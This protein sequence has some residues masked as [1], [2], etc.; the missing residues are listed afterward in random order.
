MK[1][2]P[3]LLVLAAA[4][5]LA[6]LVLR[7]DEPPTA[8]SEAANATE[9]R[10]DEPARLGLVSPESSTEARRAT[11]SD[12]ALASLEV[13]THLDCAT[14]TRPSLSLATEGGQVLRKVVATESVVFDRLAPGTYAVECSGNGW[15]AATAR[16]SVVA[17]ETTQV[18]LDPLA[19]NGVRGNVVAVDGS[20]PVRKF[21][22]ILEARQVQA[23]GQDERTQLPPI[24]VDGSSGSFCVA[25]LDVASQQLRV[26]V[27]AGERGDATS[28][29][30][31]FDGTR[32][33][34]GVVLEVRELRSSTATLSG[35]IVRA[36]D[37]TPVADARVRVLDANVS[38]SDGWWLN[39]ELAFSEAEFSEQY[40]RFPAR[41]EARSGT[42][43][44]FRIEHTPPRAVRLFVMT[45]GL[46]PEL[47]D[48]LTLAAGDDRELP[49]IALERGAR[50]LGRIVTATAADARVERQAWLSGA[51]PRTLTRISERG[52][53]TFEG[54]TDGTWSLEIRSVD[55]QGLVPIV[56]LRTVE[57][58]DQQD[59]ALDIELGGAGNGSVVR[60]HVQLPSDAA[61][62]QWRAFVTDGEALA[63]P[64]TSAM[65]S[66]DGTFELL[67]VTP[68]AK[69]IVVI[70]LSEGMQPHA[71]GIAAVDVE[72]GRPTH[73][74]L[75]AAS[76]RVNLRVERAGASP[77]METVRIEAAETQPAAFARLVPQL[78]VAVS[79]D[80][81][82]E[83]TLYGLPPGEYSA[84]TVGLEPARFVVAANGPAALELVLR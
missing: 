3:W 39:G 73:V 42:D 10:A 44:S 1:L 14:F 72:P 78:F 75:D 66:A 82:G 46:R 68:G 74:D 27:D 36:S 62:R 15:N 6:F 11:A 9:R 53:F 23:N 33:L 63:P 48:V 50:L 64:E 58:V 45:P 80:A 37:R 69:L 52:E 4:L 61:I 20:G 17:S 41:F 47:T 25:A 60:G 70:G 19:R 32:W 65:V 16:V 71:V 28:E 54:L 81:R 34:D 18:R 12:V 76:V 67:D 13:T 77:S 7:S 24:E 51:L 31:P 22:L 5:G 21:Q 2:I 79:T 57:I 49:E 56:A 35:R 38:P 84:A 30:L 29:W 40:D 83:L 43:G 59:V 55:G 8:T 26:H